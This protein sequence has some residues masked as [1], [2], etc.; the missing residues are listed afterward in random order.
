[1]Y[2]QVQNCKR[3]LLSEDKEK[4]DSFMTT[5]RAMNVIENTFSDQEFLG[6]FFKTDINFFAY[7]VQFDQDIETNFYI[8][9]YVQKK[10]MIEHAKIIY[11]RYE[12]KLFDLTPASLLCFENSL[13]HGRHMEYIVQFARTMIVNDI[14]PDFDVT[15][16]CSVL[17]KLER[18]EYDSTVIRRELIFCH[19]DL[20]ETLMK[21][22]IFPNDM[23]IDVRHLLVL[24]NLIGPFVLALN[25]VQSFARVFYGNEYIEFKFTPQIM[26]FIKKFNW[27]NNH[28]LLYIKNTPTV[29]WIDFYYGRRSSYAGCKQFPKQEVVID[30]NPNR[31]PTEEETYNLCRRSISS[32]DEKKLATPLDIPQSLSVASYLALKNKGI[33]LIGQTRLVL[34]YYLNNESGTITVA[35]CEMI[36][37][38]HVY[39]IDF[40]KI[41]QDVFF[42]LAEHQ[43][44]LLVKCVRPLYYLYD[45]EPYQLSWLFSWFRIHNEIL[46]ITSLIDFSYQNLPKAESLA[47]MVENIDI[48]KIDTFDYISQLKDDDIFLKTIL[49]SFPQLLKTIFVGAMTTVDFINYVRENY[50]SIKFDFED[51][52]DDIIHKNIE[53]CQI[54]KMMCD[55]HDTYDFHEYAITIGCVNG[56]NIYQM[57]GRFIH[58]IIFNYMKNNDLFTKFKIGFLIE[59]NKG[60]FDPQYYENLVIDLPNAIIYWLLPDHE[61]N[62]KYIET[63]FSSLKMTKYK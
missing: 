29:E 58:P 30:D 62:I 5:Y 2:R 22:M 7:V 6:E 13:K 37:F 27:T 47:I 14:S 24:N 43:T 52:F 53:C 3:V 39:V 1:M 15:P 11:A 50:P 49:E 26:S 40:P 60:V 56:K 17:E 20:I 34:E 51:E 55:S 32:E 61:E 25:D 21:I 23:S 54:L 36:D 48:I 12:N 41:P 42:W 46:P 44:N 16:F 38:N 35:E 45:I 10:N 18:V 63:H 8:S 28:V 4:F 31:R 59:N 33:K 57:C 19:H 9:E